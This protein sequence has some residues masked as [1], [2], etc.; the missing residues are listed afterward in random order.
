[1]R[2]IKLTWNVSHL[3]PYSVPVTLSGSLFAPD[4]AIATERP[5]DLL[6]CL[7]GG[8]CSGE[9]YHPSYLDHSYSFARFM[10]ERGYLVL[11]LDTLGMGNSSKPEPEKQLTL[12]VIAAAS[13]FAARQTAVALLDGEWL[14]LPPHS[15][16]RVSGLGHSMGGMLS[17]YQQG[18]FQSF[19]RL[20]VAGWS[21]LPLELGDTDV[22]SVQASLS[23]G[24]YIPTDRQTMRGFF[25]LSDVPED[26]IARDDQHAGLTPVTLALAALTPGAVEDQAGAIECPVLLLY[27]EVDVSPD[28]QREASFYP[29]TSDRTV[30]LIGH[31]AHMHNMASSRLQIW[32][33][34]DTWLQAH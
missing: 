10:T 22:A 18:R 11:A 27:G 30:T 12:E 3:T 32:Q 15:K 1:M 31:A 6:V 17:V 5:V 4:E 34:M 23:D 9:Y 16:L 20:I 14:Q 7:H 21:N 2:Q 19:E 28:P 26:L 29:H 24:G 33:A 8:S 13:D 25:H